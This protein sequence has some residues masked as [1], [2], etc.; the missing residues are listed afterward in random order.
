MDLRPGDIVVDATLGFGG[1]S[2]EILKQIGQN[3]RLVAIEKDKDVLET[4][5]AEFLSSNITL[6]HGDFRNLRKILDKNKIKSVDGILFDLG[7]S[8]YHFDASR[9]GFSFKGDEPLDMR[10]NLEDSDTAADLINGL[11]EKELADLFY[12]LANE[13]RSRQIAKAIIE[14]RRQKRIETTGE[15]TAVIERVSSRAGKIHPATKVFQGLRLAINDELGALT[16]VLPQAI[17]NLK[18]NG[19]VIVISFHSGEDRIVK[20]FFKNAQNKGEVEILTKKPIITSRQET[21]DNPRSRSAKLRA[22]KKI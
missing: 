16:E 19:R 15:L 2:R 12:T 7:V 17:D 3:G 6:E 9:R 21:L 4:A 5:K 11:T 8:S 14:A 10:L 18:K 13:R 22:A 1:H 20:N